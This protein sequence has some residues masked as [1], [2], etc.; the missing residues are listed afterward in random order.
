MDPWHGPQVCTLW[1]R[2]WWIV[3]TPEVRFLNLT[4]HVSGIVNM[5]Q[6]PYFDFA[7]PVQGSLWK[8]LPCRTMQLFMFDTTYRYLFKLFINNGTGKLETIIGWIHHSTRDLNLEWL[9]S[10]IYFGCL[11]TSFI[12]AK[13]DK[14]GL[15]NLRPVLP[16][17]HSAIYQS[18][19]RSQARPN[20]K[21][22]TDA[23]WLP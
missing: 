22:N 2:N 16:V 4:I 20:Q 7:S 9:N 1:V 15:R 5:Q 19:N 13:F 10:D 11:K 8:F 21:S 17:T 18:H 3:G 6:V 12:N 14:C 23:S